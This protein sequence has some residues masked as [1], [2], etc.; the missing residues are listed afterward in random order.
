[1]FSGDVDFMLNCCNNYGIVEVK[2]SEKSENMSRR[3]NKI[4][5]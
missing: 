2:K 1:M 4:Y 3:F 5:G